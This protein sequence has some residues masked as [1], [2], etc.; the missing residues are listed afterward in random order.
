MAGGAP[1][2][3]W[4][5]G[6][7]R[8]THR[9]PRSAYLRVTNRADLPG[10]DD[11]DFVMLDRAFLTVEAR[12]GAAGSLTLIPASRYGPPEKIYIEQETDHPGRLSAKHGQ[13]RTVYFP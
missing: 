3:P 1:F 5:T 6:T 4:S 10:R 8:S 11:T 2:G 13:G 7:S 9:R 12:D